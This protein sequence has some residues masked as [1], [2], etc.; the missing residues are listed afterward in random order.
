MISP[1]GGG[2][3]HAARRLDRSIAHCPAERR[4]LRCQRAQGGEP[5]RTQET[6]HRQTARKPSPSTAGRKHTRSRSPARNISEDEKAAIL[7]VLDRSIA[8]GQMP[9]YNGDEEEAFCGELQAALRRRLRGCRQLG[10]RSALSS[11]FKALDLEPFGEVVVSA[12]TDPGGM[13]PIP[14]LNLVPVVADT[15]PDSCN[16]GPTRWPSCFRRS[17]AV[18]IAHIGGEPAPIDAIVDLAYRHGIPVIED[19]AG[20]R[21]TAARPA[22]RQLRRHR[23]LLH[24]VWQ[25]PE[26]RRP[27]RGSLHSRRGAVPRRAPRGRPGKPF[28]LPPGS[29]NVTAAQSQ[30]E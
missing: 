22:R 13:M 6:Q 21:R 28:F 16:S 8:A 12:V 7:A 15:Q 1:T 25:A 4:R 9:G 26:H 3:Q 30:S 14:L 18:V 19:C 10:Y 2:A 29:T 20:P 5:C 24:D 17:R 23:C 27:G 11:R